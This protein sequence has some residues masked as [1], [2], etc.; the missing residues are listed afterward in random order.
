[1]EITLCYGLYLLAH[2]SREKK[3]VTVLRYVLEDGVDALRESH[4]EHLVG[5]VED[6]VADIVERHLSALHEVDESSGSGN[7]NLW[8]VAQL[9]NLCDDAGTAVDGDDMQSGNVFC[10]R[11]QVV[12]NLQAE[13]A[14]GA[15]YQGLCL[16]A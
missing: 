4:V 7:D 11:V 14:C 5:F 3:G 10:K 13:L 2:G 8:S 15:Q 1:M 9:I 12:G 16:M 6:D